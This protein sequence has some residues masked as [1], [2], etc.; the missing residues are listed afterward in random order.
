MV[1]R[2]INKENFV[3][4][5]HN[6][7]KQHNIDLGIRLGVPEEQ[8][9]AIMEDQERANKLLCGHI[10]DFMVLEGYVER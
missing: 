3:E 2:P 10:Y 6:F 8:V 1:T 4:Q 5:L 9:L 7:I